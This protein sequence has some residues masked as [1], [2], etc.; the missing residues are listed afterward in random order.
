MEDD[1]YPNMICTT[2][3][4]QLQAAYNFRKR[5]LDVNSLWH[6]RQE[7]YKK[8]KQAHDNTQTVKRQCTQNIS[9]VKE[10]DVNNTTYNFTRHML[11]RVNDCETSTGQI[12]HV[13]CMLIYGYFIFSLFCKILV[14]T[15]PPPLFLIEKK[16]GSEKQVD[17]QN[18]KNETKMSVE[19]ET[20]NKMLIVKRPISNSNQQV[21]AYKDNKIIIPDGITV[22]TSKKFE[23]S[24]GIYSCTITHG[25]QES[26]FVMADGYL[27]TFGLLKGSTR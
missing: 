22:R 11:N 2:C 23:S 17:D 21:I 7:L 1:G 9:D 24:T 25:L 3:L 15:E 10:D 5:C 26:V 13:I 4:Q 8:R 14:T 27:F 12:Q 20:E 6:S 16:P 18:D 19:V